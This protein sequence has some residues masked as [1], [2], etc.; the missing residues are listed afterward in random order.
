MATTKTTKKTTARKT[1]A[2]PKANSNTQPATITTTFEGSQLSELLDN[3]GYQLGDIEDLASSDVPYL[4]SEEYAAKLEQ[5]QGRKRGAQL[6][7]QQWQLKGEIVKA[8]TEQ[9]K[10]ETLGV[11]YLSAVEGYQQAK[12][13]LTRSQIQTQL[14]GVD[15][16]MAQRDLQGKHSEAQLH[17]DAWDIKIEGLQNDVG[18]SREL[19]AQKRDAQLAQLAQARE[20]LTGLQND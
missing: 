15:V 5:V 14:A 19:L 12:H 10:T 20:R 8:Q 6:I 11:R 1:T 3:S 9:A 18:H 7:G 16:T 13:Q 17:S 2:E 4:T